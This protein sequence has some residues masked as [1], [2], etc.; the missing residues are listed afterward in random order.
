MSYVHKELA[1]G[2]WFSLSLVEQLANVGSE[3]ERAI[4]RRSEGQAD[5]ATRAM[6]RA[7]ELLCL[8]IADKKNRGRLKELCR[9]QELLADWFFGDN[10]YGSSDES[11]Q[12][13]F[14]GFAWAAQ[15]RRR[16]R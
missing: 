4:R 8:T 13:Y 2:R 14:F 15:Q 16:L 5:A 6:E 1:A 12:K 10:E 7:L 11:W 3:V 9:V